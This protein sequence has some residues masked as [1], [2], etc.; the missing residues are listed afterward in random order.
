MHERVARIVHDVVQVLASSGVGQLVERRHT[1]VGVRL[2]AWRT[3]LLPMNPA[4]PVTRTFYHRMP[5]SEL[6]PSMKR[7]ALGFTGSR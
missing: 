6:S 3:K 1:P 5:T 4:P 7:N 2:S